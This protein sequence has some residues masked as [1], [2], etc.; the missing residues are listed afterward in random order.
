MD[1]R[2]FLLAAAA[3]T[4]VAATGAGYWRWQALAPQIDYAGRQVGHF[5]RDRRALPPPSYE[6]TTDVAILGSGVAGLTAAWK[7]PIDCAAQVPMESVRSADPANCQVARHDYH[8]TTT[9]SADPCRL[10]CFLM[11]E[12]EASRNNRQGQDEL[13][14]DQ[15]L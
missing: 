4:T 8:E 15:V 11:P 5:L 2:S 9:S 7:M 13:S 3:G 10:C 6:V 1:R 14:D 12:E